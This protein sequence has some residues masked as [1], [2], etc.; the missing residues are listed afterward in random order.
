MAET[1]FC[2]ALFSK[3]REESIDLDE[4]GMML[5]GGRAHQGSPITNDVKLQELAG[6]VV[7]FMLGLY[8]QDAPDPKVVDLESQVHMLQQPTARQI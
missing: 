6:K 7:E 4:L 1:V 5:S 2:H 8:P 3:L